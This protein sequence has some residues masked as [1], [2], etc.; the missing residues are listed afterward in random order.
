MIF[1]GRNTTMLTPMMVVLRL[2]TSGGL[3]GVHL[4]EIV[5]PCMP[6]LP[7]MI[8]FWVEP[9]AQG[10]R[11]ATINT[12]WP[13]VPCNILNFFILCGQYGQLPWIHGFNCKLILRMMQNYYY[14]SK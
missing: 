3:R 8:A 7:C 10:N 6:S 1:S 14:R 2:A 11:W 5:K 9:S 4:E 13:F 12:F